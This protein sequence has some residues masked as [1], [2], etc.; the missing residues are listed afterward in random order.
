MGP[1][2][3]FELQFSNNSRC[4]TV[5]CQHCGD[6]TKYTSCP[7]ARPHIHSRCR[8]IASS[9]VIHSHF[10]FPSLSADGTSRRAS[11]ISC[12]MGLESSNK[13]ELSKLLHS[14]IRV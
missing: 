14:V 9:Y 4:K 8:N 11:R 7:G 6:D 13:Y 2:L 10:R 5:P 3:G 1:V 12:L